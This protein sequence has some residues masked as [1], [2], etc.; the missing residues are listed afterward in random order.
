[1]SGPVTAPD[2]EPVAV[3]AEP[4]VGAVDVIEGKAAMVGSLPVARVLPRRGRRTVG[5]WCFA[6]VMG[7]VADARAGGIGPHPHIGLQ[8]VTWLLEG[9]LLHLDSLGSEQ[10]IRPGQL[11]LMT[12]GEGV[13][14]AEESSGR[15]GLHGIQ[16]WIAQ[17]E[18]TRHAAPAFE[19]HAALPQLDL[20]GGTGTVLVGELD[21]VAST[22]RADTRHVGAELV[23]RDRSAVPLDAGF[24]HGLLVTEGAIDLGPTTV[25]AGH[26]AYLARGRDEL[27]IEPRGSTRLLL[28]G[29]EPFEAELVMWWNY[30]ARSRAEIVAAHADW[31]AR[32]ARFGRV[33]SSLAAID[34]DPPP[35][36]AGL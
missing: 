30:V 20:G 35:W 17:P 36:R 16:L 12:A 22:A 25:A 11:N 1:V 4:A 19:H 8:T 28:L 18:V 29:G 21:G 31:T 14:H 13:A 15:G 34:V 24:E 9:E 23:L 33:E 3:D 7:P 5:P 2:D 26:L 6:D 27:E 10:L 32:D